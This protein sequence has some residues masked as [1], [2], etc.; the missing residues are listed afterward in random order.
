MKTA[1]LESVRLT[2]ACSMLFSSEWQSSCATYSIIDLYARVRRLW[3]VVDESVFCG[4]VLLES[5]SRYRWMLLKGVTKNRVQ[6]Y[7][8]E[9]WRNN[10]IWCNKR[11]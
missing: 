6:R 9:D 8:D 1:E 10:W 3:T 5:S 11:C 7:R 4:S 2:R